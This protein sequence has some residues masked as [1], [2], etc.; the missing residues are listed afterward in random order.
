[1]SYEITLDALGDG[2]RREILALLLEK[3][4]SV[5]ELADALPVSQPAVSQHLRILREAELVWVERDGVRRISHLDTRGLDSL[6]RY[7]ESFWSGSL[8]A[9][10][11]SFEVQ[12]REGQCD[13]TGA[14][15]PVQA[16]RAGEKRVR[17]RA[18]TKEE[19]E[20]S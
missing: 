20:G 19:E 7:V 5:G 12:G 8:D 13:A 2:T 16:S 10:R 1:M 17:K 4:R 18:K 11:S 6:R 3:P 14:D 9:F 15:G